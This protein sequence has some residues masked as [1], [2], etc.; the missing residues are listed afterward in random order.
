M[1]KHPRLYL[2]LAFTFGILLTLGYK[3]FYPELEQRYRRRKRRFHY[4]LDTPSDAGPVQH[5]A[6]QEALVPGSLPAEIVD[7]T[8]PPER[9]ELDEGNVDEDGLVK[10]VDIKN[11]IEGTIGKTPLIRIKSL[12]DATGCDILA[13]AEVLSYSVAL[14]STFIRRLMLIRFHHAVSQWCR[15]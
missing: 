5:I 1:D 12:S 4:S 9:Q 7:L 11:G 3:D 14:F 6:L 2:A 13:K 10:K 15:K 8:K